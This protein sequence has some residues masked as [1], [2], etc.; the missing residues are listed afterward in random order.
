MEAVITHSIKPVITPY[1]IPFFFIISF[2]I[3][4]VF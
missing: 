1:V 2:A 4:V 3:L